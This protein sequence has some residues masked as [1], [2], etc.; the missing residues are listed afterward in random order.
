MS[1]A[2]KPTRAV[3]VAQTSTF[4]V[5]GALS[6]LDT[7][8]AAGGGGLGPHLKVERRRVLWLLGWRSTSA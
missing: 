7:N 8:P 5:C 1:A 6:F 3:G 4:E 2:C